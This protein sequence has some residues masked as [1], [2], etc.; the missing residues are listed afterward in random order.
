MATRKKHY[1]LSLKETV[2]MSGIYN[3]DMRLGKL[4]T[5]SIYWRKRGGGEYQATEAVSMT[6]W[7]TR[8]RRDGKVSN[9][10][11]RKPGKEVVES[12]DR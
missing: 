10:V 9:T 2:E 12:H 5:H 1:H 3:E 8:T 4:N 7:Q 6:G 11:Y